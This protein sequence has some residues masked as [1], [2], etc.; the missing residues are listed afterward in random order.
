MSAGFLKSWD[1]RLDVYS[2]GTNPSPRVNPFA[3]QAMKEV[4]VDISSGIQS[5]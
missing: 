2:A 1:T 3:I 4:G 5:L